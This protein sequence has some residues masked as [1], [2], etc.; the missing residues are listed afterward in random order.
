MD[1]FLKLFNDLARLWG[2]LQGEHKFIYILLAV[3]HL[4]LL[5]HGVDHDLK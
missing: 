5:H 3:A 2:V 4:A 1:Y